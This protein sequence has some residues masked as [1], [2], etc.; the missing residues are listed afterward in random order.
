MK[1]KALAYARSGKA[2][3]A[4]LGAVMVG[5]IVKASAEPIDMSGITTGL[6]A[7]VGE[8]FTSA[9]PALAIILAISIGIKV[10]KRVAS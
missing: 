8:A 9:A 10:I 4:A 6:E 3:L 2:K 7:Q 5:T 1:T